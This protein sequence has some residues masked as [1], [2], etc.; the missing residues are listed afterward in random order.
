MLKFISK[1]FLK[2]TSKVLFVF[3]GDLVLFFFNLTL[4]TIFRQNLIG[5]FTCLQY[6]S[7]YVD[8]S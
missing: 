5:I 7:F 3:P 2:N 4:S 8:G 1:T 6:L